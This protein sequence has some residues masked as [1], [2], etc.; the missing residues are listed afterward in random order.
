MSLQRTRLLAEIASQTA[1][2]NPLH[3]SVIANLDVSDL[4]TLRHNNTST[5]VTTHKRKLG[6][7]GPVSIHGVKISV[8]DTG[9][10]DVDEDLIWT[11]LLD[12]DFL[13]F[14]WAAGLLDDHGHLL[15]GDGRSHAGWWITDWWLVMGF[16]RVSSTM[17]LQ[18]LMFD[19][20]MGFRTTSC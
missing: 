19:A 4:V 15:R 7:N 3:T 14:N 12:W 1:A 16:C 2:I 13:V 9:E 6:G 8:T 11:W 17:D 5:L 18:E 10:L 20:K